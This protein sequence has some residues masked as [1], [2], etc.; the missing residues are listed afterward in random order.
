VD[1]SASCYAPRPQ[2]FSAF[3]EQGLL[4]AAFWI[5]SVAASVR[6]QLGDSTV[7]AMTTGAV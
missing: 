3:G 4:L 6:F 1:R 5:R 7:I 2:E